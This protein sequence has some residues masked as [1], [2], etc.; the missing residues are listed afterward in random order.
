MTKIN[1][2]VDSVWREFQR[3]S[4]QSF[5]RECQQFWA[6]AFGGTEE[7]IQRQASSEVEKSVVRLF[8]KTIRPLYSNLEQ[9]GSTQSDDPAEWARDQTQKMVCE[10]MAPLSG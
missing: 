5:E 1:E 7:A 3:N 6:H 9:I 10:L 8:D 4:E 2:I